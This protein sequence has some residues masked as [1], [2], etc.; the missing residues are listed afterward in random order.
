MG[1]NQDVIQGRGFEAGGALEAKQI[2]A[3]G[4]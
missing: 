3:E 1:E 4:T 2:Y